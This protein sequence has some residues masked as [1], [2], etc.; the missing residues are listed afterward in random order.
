MQNSPEHSTKLQ[1]KANTNDKSV[2]RHSSRKP[3]R[4]LPSIIAP[5]G[6]VE[7]LTIDQMI[8]TIGES[9]KC[10][11]KRL[12]YKGCPALTKRGDLAPNI[13]HIDMKR[14]KF[15]REIYYLLAT[16]FNS[17][18]ASYFTSLCKYIAWVDFNEKVPVEGDYFHSSL[19]KPY[20]TQWGEWVK[21]GVYKKGTWSNARSMLVALLKAQGRYSEAKKLP[22]ITGIKKDTQS[23]KGLDIESELKP[24]SR[25]L[26]QGFYGF[27]KHVRQGTIPTIHPIWDEEK[28][29]AQALVCQWSAKQKDGIKSS[30]RVANGANG[31]WRNQLVRIAAMLCFMFTGMN[32][33]SLLKMKRCDVRFRQVHGGK[34]LFESVKGRASHLE[35][36]NAMG[37]S[38]RA[39]EF[40]EAWLDLSALLNGDDKEGWLFP[41]FKL[42]G[43]ITNFIAVGK[44]PQTT[45][46][47]LLRYLGLTPLTA[48]ALRQT[49]SDTLF[50]IT[51]DIY[52]VSLSLNNNI[53]TVRK[54]Y[55]D[56]LEKDHERNL[57]ASMMATFNIATQNKPVKEAIDEAKYTLHDV[58]SEY[59]YNRLAKKEDSRSEVLTLSGAR[60]RNSTRG[61]VELIN[62]ALKRS[63]IDLPVQE[64]RCTDFLECF[65]CEHHRLVAA[66]DDIWLMLSFQ[67]T[68]NEM[69]QYPA[70][71]SFPQERFRKL[72]LNIEAI[73]SRFKEIDSKNYSLAEEKHKE[74]CH[75]L[76]SNLNSL[77]DLVEV[78]SWS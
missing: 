52:L 55:S 46:N 49:K 20:M 63:G 1:I 39:R 75:P 14:D 9:K 35:H 65:E 48:S 43:T 19:V 25:A 68:L 69:H 72:C 22:V 70:V 38:K 60:C 6:R 36:D 15:I 30:F 76:Y 10:H 47:T 37:F 45:L 24:V 23:Y 42:N 12:K 61:S 58:L 32:T 27:A 16:D 8:L 41:Y 50:K 21:Q 71:N 7:T 62:K 17:T 53:S 5:T 57:A 34:Y 67:D 29:N 4:I 54:S 18:S 40:I 66:E 3:V 74:A 13:E 51:E 56:G 28:F 64:R 11:F 31:T 78:F 44:S 26:F 77:N 2:V 33:S 73:L 59:E